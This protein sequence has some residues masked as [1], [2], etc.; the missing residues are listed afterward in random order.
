MQGIRILLSSFLIIFFF[1]N[2]FAQNAYNWKRDINYLLQELPKNANLFFDKN[3]KNILENELKLFS[4][5]ITDS[6]SIEELLVKIKQALA[7]F[8]CAHLNAGI[9]RTI[10]RGD[11]NDYLPLRFFEYA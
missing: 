4:E 9:Y 3:D 10:N 6:T 1:E 7:K 8:K 5:K 11:A 2:V